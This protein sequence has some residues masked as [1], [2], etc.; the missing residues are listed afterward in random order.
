MLCIF[1]YVCICAYMCMI[2]SF[3]NRSFS[4]LKWFQ[5]H[6]L[7]YN[8]KMFCCQHWLMRSFRC[9]SST[10]LSLCRS[11]PLEV[12]L[13]K[14]IW[15]IHSKLTGEHSCRTVISIKLQSN[16]I[17]IT[18]RHEC[19]RVNLLHISRTP[20]CKMTS[21]RLFLSITVHLQ[22]GNWC[23]VCDTAQWWMKDYILM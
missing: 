4:C 14:G 16:F 20:F 2:M 9:S 22:R 15:K 3:Q 7:A 11:S 5:G 19:S 18:L 13:G 8:T 6:T 12:F 21:G 23:V 17:E 10:F 1:V